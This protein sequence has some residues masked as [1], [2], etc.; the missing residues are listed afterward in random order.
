MTKPIPPEVIISDNQYGTII[1][2]P[3]GEQD[4]I[5]EDIDT[6]KIEM[7]KSGYCQIHSLTGS[8]TQIVP[9]SSHEI[10]GIGLAQGRN[11]SES[12]AIA[13]SI[14]AENGDIVLNAENGNIKLKAK[15][16]Y[17]ETIGD[18][19]DGSILIRANDHI[20]MRADEQL[21]LAGGKVCITSADSITLNAKGYLR[22]LYSDVIQGSPLSGILGTFVPGPVADLITDIV[23]T[24]K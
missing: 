4:K 11:E 22:L 23:E 1:M 14:V 9:G 15:N 7:L 12:E 6:N 19:S 13:K 24:C 2:G 5:G 21:N 3:V 20:I 17:I 16:I 18:K 10:V 8:N